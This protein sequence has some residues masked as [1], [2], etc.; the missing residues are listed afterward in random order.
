VGIFA[1][2]VFVW[3]ETKAKSPIVPLHLF[4]NR[5][6]AGINIL[7]LVHWMAINVLFFFLTLNLQQVQGFSALQAGFALFPI[8]VMLVLMGR[9]MGGLADRWG[10]KPFL[11]AGVL[12]TGLA[13]F[14]FGQMGL[15]TN[16]WWQVFP[17][18]LLY[19]LGM[20]LTIVPVTMIAMS[21]LP[22][23]FSGLAS[24]VNNAAA[25]V[26]QMIS[27][28]IFGAVI[29]VGF[30]NSLAERV[31]EL[32]IPTEAKIA[33]L[34]E[35]R[36]LGAMAIPDSV[37][38]EMF[39]VTERAIQLAFVDGFRAVMWWAAALTL[40]SAGIILFTLSNKDRTTKT[41]GHEV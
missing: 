6:F 23:E 3:V 20:G 27:I 19:G 37:G 28:A 41:P 34:D 29:F 12:L 40:V 5:I 22:D 16:Y 2:L 39:A 14:L 31:K 13:L 38:G 8:S 10:A 1:L 17:L 24:G 26:A 15:V 36:N 35:A 11:L 9:V 18:T 4:K 33:L 21:A 25:R 7:T 32:T 30:Q